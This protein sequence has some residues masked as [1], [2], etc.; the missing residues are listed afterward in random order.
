M[1]SA[2]EASSRALGQAKNTKRYEVNGKLREPEFVHAVNIDAKKPMI[3]TEVKDVQYQAYTQQL[4]DYAKMA[5]REGRVDV[6]LPPNARA[7]GPLRDEF[8]KLDSPL[9]RV[10][11][12]H[13]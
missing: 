5:G 1:K 7:S 12:P 10:D 6:A 3:M 2:T 11:L 13:D 4:R 8:E 9:N